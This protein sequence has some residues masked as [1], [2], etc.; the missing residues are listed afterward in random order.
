LKRSNNYP[1][2][3]SLRKEF[4]FFEYQSYKINLIDGVLI[5]EFSFN[6]SDKY[7]FKPRMELKIPGG[8][9]IDNTEDL[10]SAVFNI[11]MI[12][13]IS[14]W[15][16]A[17]PPNIIIKPHK[18]DN[19]QVLWWKKLYFNGLGEFF[20][21]NSIVTSLDGFVAI[22][23]VGS[24]LLPGRALLNSEKVIVPIGGGK[25]SIVSLEVLKR[26]GVDLIPMMLNPNPSRIRTVEKAAYNIENS[27]IVNRYLDKTLLQLNDSGFLNG[28]TPFS[29][30]LGFTNV[31]LS[32]LTGVGNI[33]LSN[34]NSA[35]EST[36]PGT[37][38]NHQYSKSFEFES[39]FDFYIKKYINNNLN[40]FS[41]LRPLNEI[42]IAY[43]FSRF[44]NHFESFRS[45]NVGSK[46]DKWCGN[47]AKCLFT[48]LILSPF[49]PAAKLKSI[50]GKNLLDDTGLE[51]ILMD[52]IGN[53][54]FKPFECV[55]TVD[56]VKSVIDNILKWDDGSYNGIKLLSKPLFKKPDNILALSSMLSKYNKENNL[57]AMFVEILK[58]ALDE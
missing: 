31:L 40:Y 35:N 12:E 29:A 55:G 16:T 39:D 27:L 28:H 58:K 8:I 33:A 42:Q 22:K 5:I 34:E 21:L 2:Y 26:A 18:L 37:D 48:Y 53:T 38:I 51:D 20:Y 49:I 47:C 43:L 19:E 32:L 4:D 14:Y 17:C 46:E 44:S 3:L 30:L 36:V 56:E 23:S 24:A 50:F 25:D 1:K 54:E 7:F 45:C 11:G 13:L 41:F 9:I 15:K 52:L 6:L 10:N 57:P